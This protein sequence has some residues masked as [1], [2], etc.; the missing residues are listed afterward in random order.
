M[1][2]KIIVDNH[3]KIYLDNCHKPSTYYVANDC[4]SKRYIKIK[5]DCC[6]SE[7]IK[8]KDDCC[9]TKYVKVKDC[10]SKQYIEINDSCCKK[11]VK[12][13][14]CCSNIIK[15]HKHEY[16]KKIYYCKCCDKYKIKKVKKCCC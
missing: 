10:C 14:N 16:E 7:Y 13:D 6:S 1:C 12:V 3:K 4:C 5:D 8:V 9:S 2:P 11:Y 15:V